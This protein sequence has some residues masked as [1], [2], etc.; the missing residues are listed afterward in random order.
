[1]RYFHLVKGEKS[2][3]AKKTRSPD[4]CVHSAR[5]IGGHTILF[6]VREALRSLRFTVIDFVDTCTQISHYYITIVIRSNQFQTF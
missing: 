1:M 5:T 6:I 3:A 4:K 2:H